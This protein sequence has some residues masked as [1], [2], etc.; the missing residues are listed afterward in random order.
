[1]IVRVITFCPGEI[2]AKHG[3]DY[4]LCNEIR[5]PINQILSLILTMAGSSASDLHSYPLISTAGSYCV[6]RRP[7][8]HA[9][10][11]ST[12][13]APYILLVRLNR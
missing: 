6:Y 11:V 8:C 9:L 13:C 7:R 1:M 5:W 4:K 10:G 2:C 3:E 12:F